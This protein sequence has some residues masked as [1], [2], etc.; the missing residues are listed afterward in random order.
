MEKFF[1]LKIFFVFCRD[2]F[3]IEDLVLKRWIGY[4]KELRIE[5]IK[6]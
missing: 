3:L 1:Y 4:I 6:I 5:R 2:D